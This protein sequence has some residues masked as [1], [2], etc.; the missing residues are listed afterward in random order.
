MNALVKQCRTQLLQAE[1]AGLLEKEGHLR[2]AYRALQD[3]ARTAPPA[4]I[5][6]GFFAAMLEE[7][8]HIS[9]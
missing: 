7:P 6:Q 8:V 1:A 3:A 4:D 9:A 2:R 5:R